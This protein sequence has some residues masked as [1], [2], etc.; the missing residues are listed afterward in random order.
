MTVVLRVRCN[1]GRLRA[2][3][4]C[5]TR[6][7]CT[8]QVFQTTANTE[9]AVVDDDT[10]TGKQNLATGGIGYKQK[11]QGFVSEHKNVMI[12][13]IKIKIRPSKL[14]KPF[15]VPAFRESHLYS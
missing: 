14:G 4:D 1:V 13:I 7:Q 8:L 3:L 5:A 9:H 11:L 10:C 6:A 15:G 12:I 2:K